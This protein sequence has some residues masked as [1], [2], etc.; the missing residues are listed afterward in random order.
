MTSAAPTPY[1]RLPQLVA[2]MMVCATFPLIWVGGLVTTH[3]AGM[4]VP[5]W[6]GTYGYNLFAYPL[7]TWWYGP[8]D[9]FIEHGH[10]LLG[11]LAGILTIG[12]VIAVFCYDSRKW[13][14]LAAIGALVLVVAQ[15]LLGGM[16]VLLDARQVAMIHGC[17]GP[18]F[19]AYAC[20]L[21]LATSRWWGKSKPLSQANPNRLLRAAAIA[22]VLSYVQLVL[23]ANMRHIHA[24]TPFGI[25]VAF[26]VLVAMV[27]VVQSFIVAAI[28]VMGYWKQWVVVAPALLLCGLVV[29][30]VA[31]GM[32]TF[33]VNYSFFGLEGLGPFGP[34]Y[35]I[36]AEGVLQT[37]IVTA[38]VAT[39]SLIIAT[40]AVLTLAAARILSD[41]RQGARDAMTNQ[42]ADN[43]K[44]ADRKSTAKTAVKG[45][46]R[47]KSRELQATSASFQ[48]LTHTLTLR[49][50][51]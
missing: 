29:A 12:F 9:L 49:A 20:M 18:L 16:R 11:A 27:L 6:P 39:G 33:I 21:V 36:V 30:Q 13:M 47:R 2:A 14:K 37:N 26:H 48:T 7:E 46:S 17:T 44:A 32:S 8:W 22:A 5:D 24:E 10:R 25:L 15:G 31:L 1:Y 43:G 45:T 34:G 28:A 4:A 3:N 38:H 42:K 23:G 35:V 19:F 50:S 41:S 51:R 40:S